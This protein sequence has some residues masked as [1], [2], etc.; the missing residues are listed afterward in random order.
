MF[1]EAVIKDS[2]LTCARLFCWWLRTVWTWSVTRGMILAR[3]R[4]EELG[5]WGRGQSNI[6]TK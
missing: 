6:T 3:G 5:G 2:G 4:V 1:T